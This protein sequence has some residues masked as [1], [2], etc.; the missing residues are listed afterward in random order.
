MFKIKSYGEKD[1]VLSLE[2]YFGGVRLVA[3]IGEDEWNLLEFTKEGV[4]K[5]ASVDQDLEALDVDENGYL[6]IG[7]E[8]L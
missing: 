6:V 1:A 8:E 7:E 2:T 3:T 4:F 5:C